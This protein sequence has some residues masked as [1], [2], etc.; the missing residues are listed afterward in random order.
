[1]RITATLKRRGKTRPI[2]ASSRTRPVRLTSS[3]SDTV[4]RPTAAAP[5]RRS[6]EVRSATTK[7]ARTIPRSTVC[8]IASLTI[9][10]LRRTR[11][12]PGRAHAAAATAPISWI[13]SWGAVIRDLPAEALL[14]LRAPG[15]RERPLVLA[16]APRPPARLE[17]AQAA[18]DRAAAPHHAEDGRRV[19]VVERA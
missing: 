8:V 6:G 7:N 9:A 5:T 1:M 13:S 12:T 17:L 19:A 10:M 14:G 18:F 16:G 15:P 11:K 2:A 3:I 4:A